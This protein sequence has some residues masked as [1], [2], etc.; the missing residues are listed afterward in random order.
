MKPWIMIGIRAHI[1]SWKKWLKCPSLSKLEN[2]Q[3]LYVRLHNVGYY[4]T[5]WAVHDHGFIGGS[6]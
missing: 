5:P 1:G 2:Y 4:F 3:S 6:S